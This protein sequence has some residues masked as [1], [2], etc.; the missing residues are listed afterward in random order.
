M[1]TGNRFR[2]GAVLALAGLVVAVSAPGLAAAAIPLVLVAACPVSMFVMMRSMPGQAP[3][4]TADASPD[5]ASDL[6]RELADLAEHQ[7]RLEAELARQG[8]SSHSP[9]VAP[10]GSWPARDG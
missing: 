9:A 8:Q 1:S 7:R 6:R 5:R 2:V 3:D 4:R 10:T